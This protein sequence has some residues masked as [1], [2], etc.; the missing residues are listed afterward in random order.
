[1]NK[2]NW[3][4][5]KLNQGKPL[6]NSIKLKISSSIRKSYKQGR[7]VWNKGQSLPDEI[8]QKI[9]KSKKG[10][11]P[12]NKGIPRTSEERKKISLAKKGS[13]P[14]NKGRKWLDKEKM[15]IS[16]GLKKFWEKRKKTI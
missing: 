8:K 5:G 1:M 13:I 2:S 14:W 15:D 10:S 9:S 7:K 11:K 16:I 4:I 12:W 3:D 6:S